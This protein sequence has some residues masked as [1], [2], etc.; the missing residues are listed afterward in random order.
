MRRRPDASKP[1]KPATR[2]ARRHGDA[3]AMAH[4]DADPDA[5]GH[6]DDARTRRA[7]AA[8]RRVSAGRRASIR[9]RCR[10]RSRAQ[11]VRL[12][13]GDTL[14]L[15]ATLVRRTINRRTF[16]MYGFNGQVPGPLIRVAAERDDHRALSQPH[17]SA[18]HGALARRAS[19]QS[20]R[21]RAGPDAGLGAAGRATS[22]TPCTFPTRASTGITRTCAR[23]SSRRWGCSA[24]CSSTRRTATTT[25][26]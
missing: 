18:E 22:R 16:V 24:T 19:R 10:R 1:A 20:L 26:R 6:A 4:V 21:R 23:T 9:G 8:R 3:M 13:D 12:K 15:T 7:H 11:I 25:R 5:E 17:R 14:D 2:S